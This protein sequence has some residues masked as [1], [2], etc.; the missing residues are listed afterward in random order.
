MS[1]ADET[2]GKGIFCGFVTAVQRMLCDK[3]PTLQNGDNLFIIK[4]DGGLEAVTGKE[5]KERW[6][7]NG[8][9]AYM[10]IQVRSRDNR[11]MV[12][13]YIL[14]KFPESGRTARIG[15]DIYENGGK[16]HLCARFDEFSADAV[17]GLMLAIC[18]GNPDA[19]PAHWHIPLKWISIYR[20]TAESGPGLPAYS[21]LHHKCAG[22]A[23]YVRTV[24]FVFV[25]VAGA[26]GWGSSG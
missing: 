1:L 24:Y 23:A 19:M 11:C 12:H 22:A 14:Q 8:H 17:A 15:L 16:L 5:K 18:T 2:F 25:C 20:R 21:V 7:A 13:A 6:H 9:V 3:R 10:R 26:Q 4:A